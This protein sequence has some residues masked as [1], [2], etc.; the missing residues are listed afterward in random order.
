MAGTIPSYPSARNS[1]WIA[2]IT[3][4]PGRK[5]RAEQDCNEGPNSGPS[6]TE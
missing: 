2:Q 3:E 4:S 1:T 5:S 6:G